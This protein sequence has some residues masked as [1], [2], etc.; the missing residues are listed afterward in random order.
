MFYFNSTLS[1]SIIYIAIA[2]NVIIILISSIVVSVIQKS[3]LIQ[4]TWLII[5]NK[6][7]CSYLFD[8]LAGVG[9]VHVE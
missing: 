5:N 9:S 7:L 1:P 4:W 3:I 8:L 2:V 6:I